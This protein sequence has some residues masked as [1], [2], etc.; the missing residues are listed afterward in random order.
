MSITI[1]I[2]VYS[3][4]SQLTPLS[5][6][7]LPLLLFSLLYTPP[8]LS[9]SLPQLFNEAPN[10]LINKVA[11][12]KQACMCLWHAKMLKLLPFCGL[13]LGLPLLFEVALLLGNSICVLIV[14]QIMEQFCFVCLRCQLS[15]ISLS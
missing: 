11:P 3:T 15:V 1:C 13:S 6:T 7:L 5:S 4:R 9:F 2:P 8:S 10:C 14:W 12:A